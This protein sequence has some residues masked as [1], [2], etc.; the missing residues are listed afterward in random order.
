MNTIWT[1]LE[2]L[3]TLPAYLFAAFASGFTAKEILSFSARK[4]RMWKEK[5]IDR[6]VVMYLLSELELHPSPPAD[7]YGQVSTP[8]YRSSQEI[9]AVLGRK[10]ADI[11]L[12]L[13]RLERERLVKRHAPLNDLWTASA[14]SIWDARRPAGITA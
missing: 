11:I 13:E 14:Y 1:H 12:R 3:R 2:K 9:S 4:I 8:Y 10:S 6:R 7:S 5:K